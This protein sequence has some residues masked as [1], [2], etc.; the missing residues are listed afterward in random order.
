MSLFAYIT[1]LLDC[2]DMTDAKP[3]SYFMDISFWLQK[4]DKCFEDEFPHIKSVERL[5]YLAT[6]TRPDTVNSVSQFKSVF[7][8]FW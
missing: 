6:S 5:M 1:K 8:L 3:L 2:F 4:I 7:E